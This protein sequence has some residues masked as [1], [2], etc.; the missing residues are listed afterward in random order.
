MESNG[1]SRSSSNEFDGGG[2]FDEVAHLVQ[3]NS[4]GEESNHRGPFAL[5][6]D[7]PPCVH[8]LAEFGVLDAVES[9]YGVQ[10]RRLVADS[11]LPVMGEGTNAFEF[12][13]FDVKHGA[14]VQPFH[15][16]LG[17]GKQFVHILFLADGQR[18]WFLAFTADTQVGDDVEDTILLEGDTG[19]QCSLLGR[20]ERVCSDM[21]LCGTFGGCAVEH[22]TQDGFPNILGNLL[23][24]EDTSE[25]TRIV[26]LHETAWQ[27][28]LTVFC[29][30]TNPHEILIT[31][32]KRQCDEL[33]RSHIIVQFHSKTG[34]HTLFQI[35]VLVGRLHILEQGFDTTIGVAPTAMACDMSDSHDH[36]PVTLVL[37][38]DV[39]GC[40]CGADVPVFVESM[41][42]FRHV[43]YRITQLV[44]LT[45]ELVETM[46]A[47]F[48]HVA[49]SS[50]DSGHGFAGGAGLVLG[51]VYSAVVNVAEGFE[52]CCRVAVG[53]ELDCRES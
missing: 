43:V 39:G 24:G 22:G 8:H 7:I 38:G 50:G 36:H 33:R 30:G 45:V 13:A 18:T 21:L 29:A 9:D 10:Y 37:V 16:F 34:L 14:H 27:N 49:G 20:V 5:G 25:F 12:V 17:G 19:F 11:F 44:E 26:G 6:G 52:Q 28:T 1:V 51:R 41:L 4:V 47:A 48:A 53:V 2:V 15:V 46:A 40:Q 42:A 31:V 32:G 35:L 23:D 3:V